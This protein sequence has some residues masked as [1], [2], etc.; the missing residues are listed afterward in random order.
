LA[1]HHHRPPRY[2]LPHSVSPIGSR[3]LKAR[4][5]LTALDCWSMLVLLVLTSNCCFNV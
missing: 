2:E 4:G 3:Q 1:L 5:N